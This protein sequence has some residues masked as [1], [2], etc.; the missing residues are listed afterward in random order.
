MKDLQIIVVGGKEINKI[1]EGLKK[2]PCEEAIF[3]SSSIPETIETTKKLRKKLSLLI[4]TK[5]VILH[6]HNLKQAINIFIK[7]YQQNIESYR[8]I[9]VNISDGTKIVAIAAVIAAQ[10]YPVQ[11]IYAVPAKYTTAGVIRTKRIKEIIELPIFHLQK[12]LLP[13]RSVKEILNL[14]DKKISFTNLIKKYA[15]KPLTDLEMRTLKSR[16]FYTLK[17]LKE[18]NLIRTDL[19]N[20]QLYIQLSETGKLLLKISLNK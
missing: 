2:Y 7:L 5:R 14:L 13:Q 15:G 20:R 9:Y 11:V 18:N 3:I 6:Y 4:K 10:Y 1:L 8:R 12:L 17:K 19:R 16:F